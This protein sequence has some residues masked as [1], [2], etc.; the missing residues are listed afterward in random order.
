MFMIEE[1]TE[2]VQRR[3]YALM[4]SIEAHGPP[5]SVHRIHQYRFVRGGVNP[6][7]VFFGFLGLFFL[8]VSLWVL[9][10]F[11]DGLINRAEGDVMWLLVILVYIGFGFGAWLGYRVSMGN[12]PYAYTKPEDIEVKI[13]F[14]PANRFLA[15]ILHPSDQKTGARRFPELNDACFVM[16]TFTVKVRTGADGW[17]G[18]GAYS[19]VEVGNSSHHFVIDSDVWGEEAER[20]AKAIAERTGLR[21]YKS[22]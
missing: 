7:A 8:C 10:S 9:F 19:F 21:H 22:Q 2:R 12:L 18:E 4:D 1:R 14:D 13:W 16:P 11:T 17:Q 6:E 3:G 15:S 20:L 5:A